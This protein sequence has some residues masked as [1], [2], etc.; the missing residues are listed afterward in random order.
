MSIYIYIYISYI[1]HTYDYR[2]DMYKC[3][4]IYI[5]IHV[6]LYIMVYLDRCGIVEPCLAKGEDLVTP[7]GHWA[8][9]SATSNLG[10]ENLRSGHSHLPGVYNIAI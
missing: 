4:Y 9:L 7:L 5:H 2:I 3:I 10:G 6:Y 1:I 8:W